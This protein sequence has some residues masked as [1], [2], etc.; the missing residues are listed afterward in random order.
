MGSNPELLN[1]M[2]S[3]LAV[4][5]DLNIS[6]LEMRCYLF[7]YLCMYLYADALNNSYSKAFYDRTMNWK[8]VE[9]SGRG[10]IETNVLEFS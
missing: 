9:G 4:N 2:V 10:L 8:D 7:I 3:T 5:L 6:V 1:I